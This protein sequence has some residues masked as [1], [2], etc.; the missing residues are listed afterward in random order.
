MIT[1]MTSNA[2]IVSCHDRLNIRMSDSPIRED[3]CHEL[4]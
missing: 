3:G 1:G 4:E 2:A